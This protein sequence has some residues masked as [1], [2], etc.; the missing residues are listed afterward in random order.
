MFK[1]ALI[2]ESSHWV[3]KNS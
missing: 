3:I 2:E 1:F